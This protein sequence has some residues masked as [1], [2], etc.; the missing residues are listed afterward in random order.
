MSLL[1]IEER[2]AR[3]ETLVEHGFRSFNQNLVAHTE[4]DKDAFQEIKAEL[5]AIRHRLDDHQRE[6]TKQI[7]KLSAAILVLAS[8]GGGVIST[9]IQRLLQGI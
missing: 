5:K 3:V 9:F 2:L 4:S 8:A 6:N 7:Y 1:T